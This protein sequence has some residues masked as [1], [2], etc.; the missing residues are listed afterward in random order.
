[1]IPDKIGSL[2][3]LLRSWILEPDWPVGIVALPLTKCDLE[4]GTSL[5]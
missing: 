2:E 5:L 4:Q 1:M 3:F